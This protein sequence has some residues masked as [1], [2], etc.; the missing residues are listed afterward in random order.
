[1]LGIHIKY[2]IFYFN[3]YVFEKP[4]DARAYCD[5]SHFITL[6]NYYIK[7]HIKKITKTSVIYLTNINIDEIFKK[8]NKTTRNEINKTYTMSNINFKIPSNDYLNF[9]LLYQEFENNKKRLKFLPSLSQIKDNSKLFCAYYQNTMISA[10]LCFDDG[11]RLRA[12]IICSKR[13]SDQNSEIKKLSGYATRRLIYEICNYGI[14]N[15]YLFFDLGGICTNENDIKYSITKFKL[16]F[17]GKI[18]N[19]YNYYKIYNPFLKILALF[20]RVEYF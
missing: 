16:G 5:Q 15:K 17:G 7:N 1:M 18:I 3:T 11:K 10:I 9:Y 19:T 14:K 13:L 2:K 4:H 8:F 20:F 6:K 12:N